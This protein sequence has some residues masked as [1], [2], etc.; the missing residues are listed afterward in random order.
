[1]K[2]YNQTVMQ[3]D[4]GL[5]KGLLAYE[6]QLKEAITVLD[7]AARRYAQHESDQT[8]LVLRLGAETRA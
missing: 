4:T 7:D 3:S 8:D 2:H 6:R 5:Y 1:M